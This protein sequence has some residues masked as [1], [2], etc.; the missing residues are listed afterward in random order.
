VPQP[1]VINFLLVSNISRLMLSVTSFASP[2]SSMDRVNLCFCIHTPVGSKT[3]ASSTA[4]QVR[5]LRVPPD[6]EAGSEQF[7][8]ATAIFDGRKK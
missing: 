2:S 7:I 5:P 8:A 1:V 3:N 4:V 6:T